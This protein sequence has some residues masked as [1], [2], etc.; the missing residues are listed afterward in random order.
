[1]S[2]WR[3]VRRPS[4]NAFEIRAHQRQPHLGIP[5][6]TAD[7]H[8]ASIYLREIEHMIEIVDN[9]GKIPMNRAMIGYLR[10][11]GLME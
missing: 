11:S 10:F 5:I 3:G 9:L 1:M 7:R 6:K 4:S 2:A 8:R